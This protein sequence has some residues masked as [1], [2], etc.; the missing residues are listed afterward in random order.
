M[1]ILVIKDS[2][3]K[4]ELRGIATTGIQGT[5]FVLKLDEKFGGVPEEIVVFSGRLSAGYAG[6]LSRKKHQATHIRPG[7]SIIVIG[8]MIREIEGKDKREYFRMHATHIYNETLKC[9]F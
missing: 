7:D 5:S 3:F 4:G 9:G 8:E 1:L 2:V 6:A